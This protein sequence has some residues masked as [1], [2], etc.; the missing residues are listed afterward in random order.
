MSSPKF[1]DASVAL[2]VFS[3][4]PSVSAQEP[5][6]DAE[7]KMATKYRKYAVV[8][9]TTDVS[10]L[11]DAEKKMIPL[12]IDAAAQMDQIFWLEAYGNKEE[13]LSSITDVDTHRFAEINYG[14][15]DRLAGNKPFVD[16]YVTF[17]AS[18]FRSIRFG[19][20]S[21]HGRANTLRFNFF[22]EHDAF[23]RDDS[24]RYRVDF[25]NMKA[26]MTLL[27]QNILKI[28][29][30]GDYAA[31]TRFMNE[32]GSVRETLQADLE[33]VNRAGIP[34][35]VVFEKG[36]SVLGLTGDDGL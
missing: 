6:P 10:K 32:M 14:P 35:D 34:V 11:S 33:R 17:M 28:Q 4:L 27:G 25:E 22:N 31:A 23:T 36:V 19:A 3:I 29:G 5:N 30:D 2:L 13:L 26:A 15:W 16:D 8:R 7:T 21:A 24:G 1:R 12:L 18:I 9:L 20:S